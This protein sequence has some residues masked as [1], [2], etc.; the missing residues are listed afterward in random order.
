[1]NGT[2]IKKK[3]IRIQ[4]RWIKKKKIIKP[5]KKLRET[6]KKKMDGKKEK[7]MRNQKWMLVGE[8]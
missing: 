4:N 8:L 6:R 1:M 2:F 5:I 7:Q 3:S